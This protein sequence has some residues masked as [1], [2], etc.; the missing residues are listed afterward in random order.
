MAGGMLETALLGAVVV[1][2]LLVVALMASIAAQLRGLRREAE[3]S[4]GQLMKMDWSQLLHN[5]IQHLR[6]AREALDTI[7][8][9]LQKLEALEKVQISHINLRAGR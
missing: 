7:D 3:M 2:L 1:L 8:K 4:R 5:G 6:E 9:R